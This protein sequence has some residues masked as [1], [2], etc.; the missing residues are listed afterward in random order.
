LLQLPSAAQSETRQPTPALLQLSVPRRSAP[1]NALD[2]CEEIGFAPT[3]QVIVKS[4]P[5]ASI[6][7]IDNGP[8]TRAETVKALLDFSV[9]V[10]SREA[11]ASPTRGAQG[12]ALK[13]LSV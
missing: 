3:I 9:R 7:I 10:S 6:T 8:G 1:S 5:N 13:T 2:A 4:T 12:N 11:Y